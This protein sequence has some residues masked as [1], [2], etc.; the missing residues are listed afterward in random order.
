MKMSGAAILLVISVQLTSGQ[1]T[2]SQSSPFGITTLSTTSKT[3]SFADEVGAKSIR[4]AGPQAIIWDRVK[5]QGWNE[6]D[7]IISDLYKS[8]LEISVVVLG[9]NPAASGNLVEYSTFINE[10][11]ERYDGDGINDAPGSPVV[12]Y[13]EID[14]EPDLY[15]PNENTDWKGNLSETKDY[16]VV[17]KTAYEAIKSANPNAKVAIAGEAFAA[18]NSKEY[19]ESILTELDKLKTNV[20]DKFFDVYNLHYYGFYNEYLVSQISD[21]KL[22]L[23][24]HGCSN[25]E[26]IVTET[27]TYSGTS[28]FGGISN[29]L[30]YQS[31]EQQA[32][33]LIKRYVYSKANGT[34]KI[35]WYMQHAEN[36]LSSS[37]GNKLLA[38][39]S[40]KKMT[41]IL[42][43]SDW[44]NVETI[45]EV[46]G[47]YIYKFTKP[48]G[49][50]YVAWNDSGAESVITISGINH[51]QAKVSE[52]VPMYASGDGVS[53][54]ATA[55]RT[56][57]Y[58]ATSGSIVLTIGEKPVFVE[59][60]GA[61][62]VQNGYENIPQEFV[63]YQNYPNPFNPTTTICFSLLKREY[64]TLKIF[65][66]LGKEIALLVDE[67]R[68]AGEYSLQFNPGY[69]TSGIYFYQLNAGGNIQT[70]KMILL[71]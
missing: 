49:A 1:P 59:P 40:F 57:T 31:E 47:I 58:T 54:F 24:K 41:E 32:E 38:Y 71:K 10:M 4:L 13:F 17:L 3:I 26:K 43:G 34:N 68:N 7:K 12:T 21:V 61:T 45:Q 53:D 8:S 55:F 25:V 69:L 36:G 39:Y 67:E 27:A 15:E 37:N 56:N 65:D 70:K 48:G 64:V 5:S 30:P 18:P 28:M 51:S 66:I 63:L 33:S 22:L 19:Y 11:A 60:F 9:G 52:T 6:N 23:S 20:N 29:N 2:D 50:V 62:S 14:N 46:D 44:N 42:A 35:Y 16:A